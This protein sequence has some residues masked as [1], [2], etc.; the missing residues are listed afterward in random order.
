HQGFGIRSLAARLRLRPT[1]CFP[2]MHRCHASAARR[3][4]RRESRWSHDMNHVQSQTVL[5]PPPTRELPALFTVPVVDPGTANALRRTT[6]PEGGRDKRRPKL[7]VPLPKSFREPTIRTLP[8]KMD[9]ASAPVLLVPAHVRGPV[10]EIV[11]SS[12]RTQGS[13]VMDFSWM[14]A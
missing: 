12:A 3:D 13:F 11:Q 5:A 9:E 2:G 8:D 10:A 7:G 6:A 14:A 4:D 1:I